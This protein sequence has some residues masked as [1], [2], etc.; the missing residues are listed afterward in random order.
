[1]ATCKVG[2]MARPGDADEVTARFRDRQADLALTLT[3]VRRV[4]EEGQLPS[5]A[6]SS[7]LAKG[8]LAVSVGLGLAV[9]Y[10]RSNAYPDSY[11]LAFMLL[12]STAI[13]LG[14]LTVILTVSEW[15]NA[16]D[17]KRA[18]TLYYKDLENRLAFDF[19]LGKRIAE[20]VDSEQ[21]KSLYLRRSG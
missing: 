13:S 5:R 4:Q 9:F 1:M 12:A 18:K 6:D 15:T 7:S 21:A 3:A 20:A 14:L 10:S 2:V 16:R 19:D 17:E 8:L 11:Q